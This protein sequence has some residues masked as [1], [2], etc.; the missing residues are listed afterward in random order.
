MRLATLEYLKTGVVGGNSQDKAKL[1][2]NHKGYANPLFASWTGPEPV[3]DAHYACDPLN[4]FHLAEAFDNGTHG[5]SAIYDLAKDQ[6][7]SWCEAFDKM[8]KANRIRIILHCGDAINLCLELQRRMSIEPNSLSGQASFLGPWTS[9]PLILDGPGWDPGE[10]LFHVI[11][12]SNA[13]DHLGILTVLPA[14]APLLRHTPSSVLYTETLMLPFGDLARLMDDSLCA[15]TSLMSLL[16]GLSPCGQLS[17]ETADSNTTETW[18]LALQNGCL[19]ELR[20]CRMRTTWKFPSLGDPMARYNEM[21]KLHIDATELREFLVGLAA[22]M[23]AYGPSNL[24]SIDSTAY[25]RSQPSPSGTKLYNCLNFI[26]VIRLMER[27]IATNW[28]TCLKGT[29]SSSKISSP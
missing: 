5:A 19:G 21:Q 28:P 22:K 2:N 12:T 16:I 20:H 11:D 6:F 7:H 26:Q 9:T 15:S 25:E 1:G 3:Y 27:N 4:G 29:Q 14:A 8:V 18:I 23:F 24:R 17:S 13:T 10:T